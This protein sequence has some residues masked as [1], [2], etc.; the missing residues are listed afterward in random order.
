MRCHSRNEGKVDHCVFVMRSNELKLTK[1]FCWFDIV[2]VL[3]IRFVTM[4][5]VVFSTHS[6]HTPTVTERVPFLPVSVDGSLPLLAGLSGGA[7]VFLFDVVNETRKFL[8]GETCLLNTAF[9]PSGVVHMYNK[10]VPE[11]PVFVP[12]QMKLPKPGGGIVP[13][14]PKLWPKVWDAMS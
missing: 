9:A 3:S 8:L 14:A 4:L 10:V 1:S 6:L 7:V 13:K 5:L 12:R 11:Y 2:V